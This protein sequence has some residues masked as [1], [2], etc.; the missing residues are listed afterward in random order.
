LRDFPS[1]T[2]PFSDTVASGAVASEQLSNRESADQQ[3][4]LAALCPN[5]QSPNEAETDMNLALLKILSGKEWPPLASISEESL[6]DDDIAKAEVQTPMSS[7]N[8]SQDMPKAWMQMQCW[9]QQVSEL[10]SFFSNEI[11]SLTERV[12]RMEQGM[13]ACVTEK[14]LEMKAA[15][16]RDHF[17]NLG[18]V[19]Q[20]MEEQ[21]TAAIQHEAA[22]REQLSKVVA[23][24]LDKERE[25]R[26]NDISKLHLS[27]KAALSSNASGHTQ[28]PEAWSAGSQQGSDDDVSWNGNP[29]HMP[30]AV[31]TEWKSIAADLT[32]LR[33]LLKGEMLQ[34][35]ASAGDPRD[36]LRSLLEG[37]MLQSKASAGDPRALSAN[38]AALKSRLSSAV[39]SK[40]NALEWGPQILVAPTRATSVANIVNGQLKVATSPERSHSLDT[41]PNFSSQ[42]RGRSPEALVL[43]RYGQRLH[44][45]VRL[46]SNT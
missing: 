11:T 39:L 26:V 19:I 17:K 24:A 38:A 37:E 27:F 14:H 5:E 30:D 32:E 34:S 8:N 1:E 16:T 20:Q 10:M 33:G 15:G 46:T 44:N 25:S 4:L 31:G 45:T 12:N 35:K 29:T 41:R 7:P 21:I 23:D 36:V 9:G 18:I 22:L 43:P 42:T 13:K 40:P 3:A 28:T 6:P 2:F